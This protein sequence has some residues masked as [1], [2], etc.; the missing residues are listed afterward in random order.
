MSARDAS[1][2]TPQRQRLLRGDQVVAA[3]VVVADRILARM[4]GLLG[5]SALGRDE[6]LWI[7]P[8]SSIHMFFMRFAIDA[9]FVDRHL[10]IVRLCTGVRPWRMARGGRGAHSVFELAVGAIERSGLAVGDVLALGEGP[11]RR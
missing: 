3:D 2:R 6:A 1:P 4:R 11:S 8:C 10:R 9:V 7:L 5:R